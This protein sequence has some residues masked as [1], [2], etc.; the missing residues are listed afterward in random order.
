MYAAG[1]LDEGIRLVELQND[2]TNYL[3]ATQ[4]NQRIQSKILLANSEINAVAAELDCEGQRMDQLSQYVEAINAK[5][6]NRLTVKSIVIGAATGIASA[7]VSNSNWVKGI[8]IGGGISGAGISIATLNPK[9]SKI[10]I[11]HKRNLLR[12]VWLQENNNE[13]SPFLWL[14]LT[15]KRISNAGTNAI[16][17]NLKHRWIRFQ[18]NGDEVAAAASVIFTEGGI[19]RA[20]E[21]RNRAAMINQLKVEIR[22]LEQYIHVLMQELQQRQ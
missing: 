20:D 15:E 3:K 6:T 14:M 18:F 21:L 12:N 11:A 22:S 4:L 17:S 7:L 9:G 13:I 16:L 5:Q 8:A 1:M 19:Y 2:T 10:E